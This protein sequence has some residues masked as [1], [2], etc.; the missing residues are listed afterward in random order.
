MFVSES[1]KIVGEQID[2]AIKYDGHYYL[3][4]LKW[5]KEPCNQAQIASLYLKAEGKMETR[6]IFISMNGFSSEILKSLPE[7][8]TKVLLLN[9]T[10]FMNVIKG[11][12]TFKQL[13]DYALA[14]ASL[15][16]NIYCD[17]NIFNS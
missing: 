12:Y 13:L 17:A 10:H 4:E 9:G 6:G 14:Q 5:V 3:I 15:K 2:G 1:F 7:K 8:N 16:N 11:I